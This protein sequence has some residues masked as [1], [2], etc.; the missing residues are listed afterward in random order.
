MTYVG[1][2]ECKIGVWCQIEPKKDDDTAVE[3]TVT[4]RGS[5]ESMWRV[6]AR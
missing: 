1:Y 6:S 5:P 4:V 3:R 2:E